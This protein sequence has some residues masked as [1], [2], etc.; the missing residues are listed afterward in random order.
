MRF[1]NLMSGK[2]QVFFHRELWKPDSIMKFAKWHHAEW[3]YYILAYTRRAFHVRLG[4]MR[5][6]ALLQTMI[7]IEWRQI[8][9]S[10]LMQ[11]GGCALSRTERITRGYSNCFISLIRKILPLMWCRCIQHTKHHQVSLIC[12]YWHDFCQ[13]WVIWVCYLLLH[14]PGLQ[15]GRPAQE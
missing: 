2:H 3:K 9:K 13:R 1:C 15:A 5:G 10:H 7:H 4:D 8:L 12:F 11:T 14:W 6:W